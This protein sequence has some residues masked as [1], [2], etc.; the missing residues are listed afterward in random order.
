MKGER[1]GPLEADERGQ[2]LLPCLLPAR[3]FSFLA[4]LF[5]LVVWCLRKEAN[6]RTEGG[7]EGDKKLPDFVLLGSRF[8]R[9]EEAVTERRNG[10]SGHSKSALR[11][12]LMASSA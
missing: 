7:K 3:F 11:Q 5:E 9:G 1:V 2:L 10:Q 6:V 4:S 12:F 8:V